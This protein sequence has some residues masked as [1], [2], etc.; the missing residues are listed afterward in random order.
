VNERRLYVYYRVPRGDEAAVVQA[1][2][3]LQRQWHAADRALH[4]DLLRR[5]DDN[6]AN[7]V[8]LMETYSAAGGVSPDW[9]ARIESEATAA[10]APWPCSARH[11]EVF[12]PC[13]SA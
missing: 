1:V 8:T 11:V 3:A 12:A 4:C 13:T 9:Q 7:D 2:H 5:D 6:S 10:L